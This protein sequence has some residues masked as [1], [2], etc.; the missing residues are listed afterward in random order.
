MNF[1]QVGHIT[2]CRDPAQ[3]DMGELLTWTFVLVRW[4]V[5]R[6]GPVRKE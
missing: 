5:Y 3:N 1:T 4:N 2:C 6:T